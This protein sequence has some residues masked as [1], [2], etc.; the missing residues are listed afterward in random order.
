MDWSHTINQN[1]LQ[2][3]VRD[4]TIDPD[5]ILDSISSLVMI[6]D[7]DGTILYW[8]GGGKDIFGYTAGEAV[9]K[10]VGL[11]YPE[12][13]K[14]GFS[15][16]LS[17]MQNGKAIGGEWKGRHKDGFTVWVEARCILIEGVHDHKVVL[18]TASD[19]S[20]Q[21][22]IES[23][24][25]ENR[26]RTQA[27]LETAVDGIIIIN[28]Q[29]TI[30]SFNLA[31]ERIFGYRAIEMIG[32]N[33]N[34]LMPSPHREKHETYLKNYL[35]TGE[36]KI[37]GIGREVTGRR[38]DGTIFPMELSVSEAK[39]NS[40]R[41][42]TGV[43]KDISRRRELEREVLKVSEN[44]RQR[45]G[46]DLHDGLGQ[47]LTGMGLI[48][49]NVARKLE[50]NGL[51]G[52][53]DVREISVMIRQADEQ[54][55]SLARGLVHVDLETNGLKVA[56][57]KLCKRV[58]KMFSISC[59]FN[60]NDNIIVD[61]YITSLN[62][63]RIAQEAINNAVKHGK[64]FNIDVR[65]ER[66]NKH[67]CLEITDNGIG[68]DHSENQQKTKGMGIRI[69]QYRSNIINGHL[70]IVRTFDNRTRVTCVVPCGE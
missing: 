17:R 67:I 8:N 29:G 5:L 46:Q 13:S 31:A 57:E 34:V 14:K 49:Q 54:A 66:N 63:Y 25:L 4:S 41:I 59:S 32:K 45:I 1:K 35:E 38:K 62:L 23:E 21:K 37:I 20:V 43:V 39:W 27:I 58:E 64:A 19:I 48:A 44:E 40:N 9:G 28:E 2:F 15:E 50:A 10:P 42:F 65:L 56:L 61:E 60:S 26:A 47:M 55:R 18:E 53:E 22:K 69:M 51:P 6:V 52:S 11:L 3:N 30:K 33:V 7:M 68:F 12:R 70:D 36:K 16:E 24:L